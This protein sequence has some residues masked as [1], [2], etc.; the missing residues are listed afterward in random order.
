MGSIKNKSQRE[1]KI[2]LPTVNRSTKRTIAIG[3]EH[4]ENIV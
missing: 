3:S 2:L 1:L 4:E